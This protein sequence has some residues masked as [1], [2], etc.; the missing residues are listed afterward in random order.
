MA[1][2]IKMIPVSEQQKKHNVKMLTSL[3]ENLNIHNKK[4]VI[5]KIKK[6]Q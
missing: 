6:E 5:K 1:K 3:I 4:E 2:I